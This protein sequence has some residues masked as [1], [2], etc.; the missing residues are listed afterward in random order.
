[1]ENPVQRLESGTQRQAFHN[2]QFSM[3]N[4]C[5][6][7]YA[8]FRSDACRKASPVPDLYICLNWAVCNNFGPLVRKEL[9]PYTL[10]TTTVVMGQFQVL[11]ILNIS[12]YLVSYQTTCQDFMSSNNDIMLLNSEYPTNSCYYIQCEYIVA[13]TC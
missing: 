2:T 10:M 12:Y 7:G 3:R 11:Q 9:T 5:M 6:G 4:V 13:V 1:M 8:Q